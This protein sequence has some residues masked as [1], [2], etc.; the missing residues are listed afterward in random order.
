M[1]DE[2][3][4]WSPTAKKVVFSDEELIE[5]LR[6]TADREE[7]AANWY[8]FYRALPQP[9]RDRLAAEARRPAR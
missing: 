7:P 8:T 4:G 1:S 3:D 9:E 5:H 6:R 2:L